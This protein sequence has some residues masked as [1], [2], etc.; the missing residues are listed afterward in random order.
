MGLMGPLWP[1]RPLGLLGLLG[2]MGLSGCSSDSEEPAQRSSD[3][4]GVLG[5]AVE[6]T[7]YVLRYD[8]NT[9]MTRSW[10]PPSGYSLYG[11][12]GKTIGIGFTQNG[13]EPQMGYFFKS[14]GKWRTNV[15]IS[16]GT[17][18]LYGY[19]PHTSGMACTLTDL[20]D[21]TASFSS[22]AKMTLTNV[23]AI[24]PSDLCVVIGAKAGTDKETV[25]G[26]RS[27]DFD[28]MAT[29]IRDG[30]EVEGNYVFLLF[31]HLYAALRIN[32]RV[33]SEYDALR[34]IVLKSLRLSTAVNTS[35]SKDMTDIVVSL[36]KTDGTDPG[37]SPITDISFEPKGSEN[38][39]GMEFWSS[40]GDALTTS[41]N[42]YIAHFMPQD[43]TTL[44]LTSVY[45]VYDKKG[46]LIRKDATARNTMRLSDLLTGQETTRRGSRYTINMTIRPTY[47]Y[48]LSEPDLDSPAVTI[49]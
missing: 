35:P 32:M 16:A 42:T 18:Q 3:V 39:D 17:Y 46:N 49:E 37:E 15:E 44:I 19:V 22:G 8:E 31:D 48:V 10:T 41:Y 9:S 7:G 29:E 2:M 26:L 24:T 4:G 21:G 43:I 20:A 11:E 40:A 12:D 33:H 13:S 38:E 5:A 28:Y 23:P 6:V 25:E 30:D 14:S 27:G 34:A 45:D 1:L 47:L 36:E